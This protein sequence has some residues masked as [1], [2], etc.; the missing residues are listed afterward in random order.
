LVRREKSV[1]VKA[2]PSRVWEM[3]AFD[4]MPEW[5]DGWEKAEYTSEVR[6]PED[7]YKVGTS[8]HVTESHA[9]YDLEITESL[10]NEKIMYHTKRIGGKHHFTMN[11]TY[12]MK[13]VEGGTE[14]TYTCVC[15]GGWILC[16]IIEGLLGE[17]HLGVE[18]SLNNLKS[19]LEK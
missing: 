18:T 5:M 6:T 13:P 1:I 7:K 9:K 2:P 12:I 4:K 11:L 17:K 14:V 16:D 10:E 3:L 19:I 8:A 15:Y